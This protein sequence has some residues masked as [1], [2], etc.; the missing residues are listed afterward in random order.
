MRIALAVVAAIAG[1]VIV[2]MLAQ[3]LPPYLGNERVAAAM[4]PPCPTEDSVSCYWDASTRGN[5]EGRSF[6]AHADGSVTY[7]P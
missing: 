2:A 6:I 7:T 1:G 5:G 3:N 4:L